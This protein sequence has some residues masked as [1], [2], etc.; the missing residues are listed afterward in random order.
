MSQ[1]A[2]ASARKVW[3][4]AVAGITVVGAMQQ[5]AHAAL[6]WSIV[7][8]Q[9]STTTRQLRALAVDSSGDNMYGGFIQ[10][11]STAGFRHYTLVGD[12][13]TGLGGA[14]H[15]VN[16]VDS[17][18]LRQ[19]EAAAVDD[20]GIVYGASI[21]DS[22]SS[23]PNARVTL[24]NDNF[25]D[26][27]HFSLADVTS[28]PSNATGETIGGLAVRNSFGV[29]QLY[30]SRF[31]SDT[32]YIERYV[33]GGSG[34]SDSTLTLD[35]T[36]DGDGTFNLRGVIGTA[37]NLRGIDVAADGTIFVASREDNI[38]YRVSSDL[39]SVSSTP[40]TKAMD[41]AV[42]G[43]KLYVTQYNG[44]ASAIVELLQSDLSATGN[45][46]TATGDF[47]RTNNTEGY[48]GIHIDSL[49]RM[50]IADQFYAGISTNVQ[51]RVLVSS[52]IPE[53]AALS[54]LALTA[55]L[56]LRRRR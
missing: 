37:D 39:T 16:A 21:K 12:P 4:T 31:R 43:D 7:T 52:T 42:Y 36:F 8:D 3:V 11:S 9:T 13:P 54:L 51:D 50:F 32:A 5:A 53:P 20:R 15:D 34:V 14:F 35:P 23:T 1:R 25:S 24:L 38:V 28:P 41:L 26:I 29:Y 47:P 33:V 10:G 2:R 55:P 56:V 45:V 17:T 44:T 18:T 40:L 22:T 49:G 46:H 30:V 6:S 19:A 48:A 27:K